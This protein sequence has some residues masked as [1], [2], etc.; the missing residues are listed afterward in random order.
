[1]HERRGRP[2]KPPSLRKLLSATEAETLLAQFA[3][4]AGGPVTLAIFDRRDRMLASYPPGEGSQ[5]AEAAAA[6]RR[7]DRLLVNGECQAMPILADDQLVGVLVGAPSSVHGLDDALGG[8]LAVLS[9][10]VIQAVERKALARE[11]LDRYREINLLYRLHETI[12]GHIDLN[13]V[14]ASALVES[15]RI[16]KA[17][18]GALFL[19]DEVMGQPSLLT[20]EGDTANLCHGQG[21]PQWVAQ[22]GRSAIVNDVA[23]DPRHTASHGSTEP[24]QVPAMRSLLCVPLKVRE[25]VLGVLCL[26]DKQRGEIFTAGDEKLLTALASQT[27]VAI[28]NAQQVAAR[29]RQLRRQIQE[30]RIEIDQVRKQQAVKK[31]ADSDYF[32]RLAETAQEWRDDFEHE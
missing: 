1:M 18:G 5:L 21:I 30:L 7:T 10:L 17:D 29:E 4:L 27:A 19:C 16:V 31:I 32:R 8:V 26:C 9:I 23:T 15:V 20:T 2:M 12:G 24:A 11:L 13:K 28:E 22:E 6:V 14:S 3:R 25:K